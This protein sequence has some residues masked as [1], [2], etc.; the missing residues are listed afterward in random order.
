MSSATRQQ[1]N[2]GTDAVR[3]A[4][5]INLVAALQQEDVLIGELQGALER[6]RAGIADDDPQTVD[7]STQ[8]VARTLLSL[9]EARR[10]RVAVTADLTDGM[11]ADLNTLEDVLGGPLTPELKQA[12]RSVRRAAER[13]AVDLRINQSVLR[14]ALEA[15]D[16]FLQRLFSTV[17]DPQAVYDPAEP[18]TEQSTASGMLL[19]RT[20]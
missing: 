12:R 4:R 5:T 10:H 11:S 8:A 2:S 3:S 7:S 19:N 18:G 13:A 20:A 9:D 1:P 17:G 6:Q 14:R 16:A 15:G